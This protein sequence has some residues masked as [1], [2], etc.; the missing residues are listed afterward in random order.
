VKALFL[1]DVQNDFCPGGALPVSKGNEIIP[2]LNKYIELFSKLN[3]PILASRDWH[4]KET[5]HFKKF[6]GQW[7]KH[8]I[9]ETKGAM[10]HPDLKL[11]KETI[12]ISKGMDPEKDSYSAFD[13]VDSKGT[14]LDKVLKKLNVEELYIGGLATDYCV[15][16]TVLDA[17]KLGFKVKLLMD[18]IKGVEP[19]S[20][21]KALEEMLENGVEPI[22]FAQL[23][24][25]I[26]ISDAI[27]GCDHIGILTNNSNTLIEFYTNILGFEKEK[28]D[29]LQESIAKQVFGIPSACKF[30]KLKK[31]TVKIEIFESVS[32][33][34]NKTGLH[35]WGYC[36]GDVERFAYILK[37]KKINL[38]EIERNKHKVYFVKDPDGN[39]IELRASKK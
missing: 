6:G 27:Y 1:I 13:G 34:S 31:G 22:V 38:I 15:R 36:V 3:L 18:G 29:E 35:H 5:R 17:V 4:P 19:H 39:L 12:I 20:S 16:A 11:P 8:C 14:S 30:I 2:V 25:L 33:K 10:F 26:D 21:Y 7:P 24:Q 23:S 28:S 37:S 9:Q 32:F